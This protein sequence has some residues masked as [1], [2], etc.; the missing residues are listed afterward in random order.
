MLVS[1]DPETGVALAGELL[2]AELRLLTAFSAGEAAVA[3]DDLSAD[4]AVVDLSLPDGSGADLMRSLR[5]DPLRGDFP[6]IALSARDTADVRR[7]AFADGADDYLPKPFDPAELVMRIVAVL[8]RSRRGERP[9]GTSRILAAG[10]VSIDL[11]TR[12]VTVGGRGLLL[13]PG[14][15]DLLAVLVQHAGRPVSRARLA[16]L[17]GLAGEHGSRSLDMRVQRVR[18][19]L[20]IHSDRIET[21]P[22][23]GYRF[24]AEPARGSWLPTW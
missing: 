24:R 14:E 15:L 5:A 10:P 20:G 19:R 2:R 23:L 9:D 12:E 18:R 4:L 21:I 17:L 16:E 8:R 22:R 1:P 11:R 13:S 3:L 6:L 7:Q